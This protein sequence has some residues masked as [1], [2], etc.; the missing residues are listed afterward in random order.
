MNGVIDW[1]LHAK[2]ANYESHCTIF[3][4]SLSAKVNENGPHGITHNN[5][6]H[7]SFPCRCQIQSI[8]TAASLSQGRNPKK[9]HRNCICTLLMMSMGRENDALATLIRNFMM[10]QGHLL[11]LCIARLPV[12]DIYIHIYIYIYVCMYVF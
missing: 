12:M 7:P 11:Q 6:C 9:C 3:Q 1:L 10:L 4:A 8:V 5:A 2:T